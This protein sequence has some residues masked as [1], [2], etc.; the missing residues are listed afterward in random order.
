MQ[1]TQERRNELQKNYYFLCDCKRCSTNYEQQFVNSMI[2]NNAKCKAA[3]PLGNKQKEVCF[4]FTILNLYYYSLFKKKK[5]LCYLFF[6][7]PDSVSCSKCQEKVTRDRVKMF[8]DVTD[9]TE[10]QL[11]RMRDIGCILYININLFSM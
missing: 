10:F 9:F 2:C 1:T 6:K 8:F 5:C 7:I 11:N 4:I 3:I